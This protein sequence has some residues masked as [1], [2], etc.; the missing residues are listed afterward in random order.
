MIE[1]AGQIPLRRTEAGY[2]GLASIVVSQMVSRASADA[3]WARLETLTGGV[4]PETVLAHDVPALRGIGL[5]GAGS[6]ASNR[7]STDIAAFIDGTDPGEDG[8][9]R[10][11]I[12]ADSITLQAMDTSTIDASI[13]SASVAIGVGAA[14][15]SVSVGVSLAQNEVAN[16]VSAYIANASGDGQS[17]RTRT[18]GDITIRATE[19]ASPSSE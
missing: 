1:G 19:R 15:L 3:I 8:A 5:S 13:G 6:F 4:H 9:G 18:G 10:A 16:H 11:G 14:G 17:V 2:R 7:I 12:L